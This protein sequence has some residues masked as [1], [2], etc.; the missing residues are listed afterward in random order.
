MQSLFDTLLQ[1]QIPLNI[2]I[3]SNMTNGGTNSNISSSH[4][5]TNIN[6]AKRV[7]QYRIGELQGFT[8]GRVHKEKRI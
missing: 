2:E 3:R 8:K 1:M 5:L 7:S 6:K 4:I